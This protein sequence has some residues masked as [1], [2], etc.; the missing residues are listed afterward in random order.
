MFYKISVKTLKP[1]KRNCLLFI[2]L[3]F[4]T[5]SFGQENTIIA[6]DTI[7][8][9]KNALSIQ[10]IGLAIHPKGG[11]YPHR[12]N[13]KLDPNAYLVIELG[14]LLSYEFLIKKKLYAKVSASYYSDCAGL[15]AGFAHTGIYYH[16]LNKNRHILMAGLGPTLV[17]R[18]DWH[19]FPEYTGDIFF[20][21]KV[22]GKWQYR[23]VIF[24]SI[25]Y[26]YKLNERILL[27][28]SLIP[29]GYL[30]LTT[31]IGIKFLIN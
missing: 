23:F 25:D 9:F 2:C 7:N 1:E 10:W 12:Y 6:S 3:L 8:N 30:V 21:D 31:C 29:A 17:F 18:E 5:F 22:H 26:N 16:F 14:P 20:K 4:V 27:N 13:R 11:T 28:V 15:P 19:Q 24:G